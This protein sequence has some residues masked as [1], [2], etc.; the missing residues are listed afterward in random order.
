MIDFE[1]IAAEASREAVKETLK[2]LEE[3]DPNPFNVEQTE[4]EEAEIERHKINMI[5]VEEMIAAGLRKYHE[6]V[7]REK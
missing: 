1:A 4:E 2:K 3:S 6:A 7:T 5:F